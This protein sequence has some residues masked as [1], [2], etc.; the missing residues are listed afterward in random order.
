MKTTSVMVDEIAKAVSEI[1]TGSYEQVEKGMLTLRPYATKN[2]PF[3][4]NELFR[5]HK[6]SQEEPIVHGLAMKSFHNLCRIVADNYE[7]AID[8]ETKVK[9]IMDRF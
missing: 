8:K 2:T 6:L 4:M 1:R 5:I 9:K 7:E 3:R